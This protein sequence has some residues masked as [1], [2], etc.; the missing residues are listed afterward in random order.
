[1][2][3]I[4]RM[5]VR[6]YAETYSRNRERTYLTKVGKRATVLADQAGFERQTAPA[7]RFTV[8]TYPEEILRQAFTEVRP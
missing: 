3:D 4:V 7:G 2:D 6:Q 1:M 5:T 8:G